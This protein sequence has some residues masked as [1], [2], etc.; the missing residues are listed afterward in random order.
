MTYKE[1]TE[2]FKRKLEVVSRELIK[3]EKDLIELRKTPW[4]NRNTNHDIVE[5]IL[6]K[7]R[8]HYKVEKEYLEKK[9]KEGIVARTF[10]NG[11]ESLVK[12]CPPPVKV[13]DGGFG[14]K[15]IYSGGFG[16]LMLIWG[17]CAIIFLIMLVFIM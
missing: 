2:K 7:K 12:T 4:L 15:P 13:T 5:M 9:I 14:I 1:E 17:I 11:M 6:E 10:N 8:I 16:C 3:V